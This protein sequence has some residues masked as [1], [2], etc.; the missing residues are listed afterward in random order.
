[1]EIP[2]K[3]RVK[4]A[5]GMADSGLKIRCCYGHEEIAKRMARHE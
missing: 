5:K 4:N 2:I 3:K 1:M